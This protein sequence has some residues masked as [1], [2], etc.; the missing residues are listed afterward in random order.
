MSKAKL[1]FRSAFWNHAGKI[2]EYMLMYAASIVIARGL[3]VEENGKF[4][5]LFSLSQLLLVLCSFGLE[6]SLN[7]FIPQL[8]LEKRNEKAAYILRKAL[9]IRLAAYTGVVL[10]LFV[11]LLFVSVP[12]IAE[13]GNVLLFVVV[14]TG[15]RSLFP[16]FAMVL[17][18]QLR[19]SL[20]AR[21]NL[22]IRAIEL[23]AI[24]ALTQYRFTVENLF[25]LFLT[26]SALHVLA[27]AIF[28]RSNLLGETEP[29]NMHP[30]IRFGSI[31]WLNTIVEFILGRQGDVLFLTNLLPSS[32]Q[33]GLYDV[34]YSV[35]QLATMAMT[36]G[37]SGVMFATFAQLAVTDQGA[38]DRFYGFSIRIISLLTIPVYAFVALNA[39]GF[40]AVLYSTQYIGAVALVQGIVLFRIVSRLFGGGENS[41]YLLSHNHVGTIVGIGVVAAATNFSLNLLLIPKFGAMGSVIASGCGNLIVN[42]LGALAVWRMSVNRMQFGFWLKLVAAC[43]LA[44]AVCWFAVPATDAATLFVAVLAY[45][46]VLG[47]LLFF[48]KPFTRLDYEW[49]SRVDGRVAGVLQY[50]S[51]VEVKGGR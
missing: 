1:T 32:S 41:E 16:L 25:L 26:T 31:F 33:G 44:S 8:A 17:T 51:G 15:V 49:L 18:A 11:T 5:G 28:S 35:A 7:K 36:V 29:V 19:T 39:F 22:A 20:T 9:V 47:G 38:M 46:L 6:T 2:L 37:L 21:I 23:V 48:L 34:A 4:V 42:I 10:L 12:F 24:L 14:F 30:I 40:L 43:C 3:G 27:Y 50:F 45:L 13:S